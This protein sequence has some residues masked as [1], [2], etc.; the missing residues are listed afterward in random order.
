MKIGF[1]Q[2]P[3]HDFQASSLIE[4][5]KNLGVEVYG[6]I[7]N[8][9]AKKADLEKEKVDLFVECS[10]MKVNTNLAKYLSHLQKKMLIYLNGEDLEDSHSYNISN[11]SC[12]YPDDYG[13]YFRR[14]YRKSECHENE[15]SLQFGI[16]NEY[17]KYYNPHKDGSILFPSSGEYENR[18]YIKDVLDAFHPEV[19]TG[20]I[21]N[22]FF[23]SRSPTDRTEYYTQINKASVIISAHGWGEDTAR[24]WEAVCTGACVISQ[25]FTINMNEPFTDGENILFFDHPSELS[26]ILEEISTGLIETRNIGN[27]CRE[28]ALKHHTTTKRAEYFLKEVEEYERIILTESGYTALMKK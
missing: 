14:E 17:L 21:G 24:F 11:N 6:D 12:R 7:G 26:G 22:S 25:R 4:G 20:R 13:L 19:R 2:S 5:L 10:N 27:K 9:G 23:H 8:N 3:L 18:R 15:R 16:A 28:F 1:I